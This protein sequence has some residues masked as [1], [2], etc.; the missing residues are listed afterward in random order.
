MLRSLAAVLLTAGCAGP[1]QM[2]AE[3][4]RQLDPDEGR[5]FG[6]VLVVVA[7]LAEDESSS[8]WL[9]GRKAS[10]FDYRF[11]LER[12]RDGLAD[13]QLTDTTR[14]IR[15]EPGKEEAFALDLEPGPYAFTRLEQ[16]GFS[17]LEMAVGASFYVNPGSTA[18]IGRLVVELPARTNLFSRQVVRIEDAEAAA[19][20]LL[21]AEYEPLLAGARKVLMAR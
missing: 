1:V 17:E 11:L 14:T 21:G 18:Y 16:A 9:Q 19:K 20:A 5:V 13:V 3:D 6:S 10:G 2:K 15:V 7:P 12:L 4:L 8:A